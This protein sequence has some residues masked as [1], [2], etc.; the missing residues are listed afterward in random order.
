[1]DELLHS[2]KG[3]LSRVWLASHMEKKLSK[4]QFLT[5]SISDSVQA[6]LS[7]DLLLPAEQQNTA[8]SSGKRRAQDDE[9]LQATP[10][11]LRIQGQLLLGL[12]R[13][14]SRKARYLM[15][16]CSEALVKIKLAFSTVAMQAPV[17]ATE[18]A[19]TT[20]ASQLGGLAGLGTMPAIEMDP[21]KIKAKRSAIT[22]DL[23]PVD[24]LQDWLMTQ[25]RPPS[26]PSTSSQLTQAR[27]LQADRASITLPDTRGSSPLSF[28]SGRDFGRSAPR[29]GS[30]D[31][32]SDASQSGDRADSFAGGD[33]D[34][35][36]LDLGLADHVSEKE[37]VR[38]NR[39]RRADQLR[40]QRLAQRAGGSQAEADQSEDMEV[41]LGRDAA[42]HRSDRSSILSDVAPF[43]G[44][45]DPYAIDDNEYGQGSDGSRS[46]RGGFELE[47]DLYGD[48]EQALRAQTPRSD[49][50]Q[51]SLSAL[52]MTPRTA[53]QLAKVASPTKTTTR[54]RAATRPGKLT[55]D[56]E[57]ELDE[58]SQGV[59]GQTTDEQRRARGIIIQPAYLPHSALEARL[60]EMENN[61]TRFFLPRPI[62]G[63]EGVFMWPPAGLLAPELQRMYTVP[64]KRVGRAS[65]LAP[66]RKRQRSSEDGSDRE[67]EL[68]RNA[69]PTGARMSDTRSQ[70]GFAQLDVY[71]D[72]GDSP[73][74][75][76]FDD[77][78]FE[79]EDNLWN[80]YPDVTL[81]GPEAAA[82]AKEAQLRAA[83]ASTR[84]LTPTAGDTEIKLPKGES[85]LD[86]FDEAD[87]TT[88]S[89][90]HSSPYGSQQT[91][92]TPRRR[93]PQTI[94]GTPASQSQTTSTGSVVSK[95]TIKALLVYRHVLG[96]TADITAPK[97]L[98]VQTVASS[99]TRHAASAFFFET[100]VLSSR[101]AVQPK[102]E[103]AYGDITVKAKPEFYNML[104]S[105]SLESSGSVA[106]SQGKLSTPVV[107]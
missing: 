70:D 57:I 106:A 59:I 107:A 58:T 61:P 99:A 5:L 77:G 23:A 71:D 101:G 86:V 15:E 92:S 14:Y 73:T 54:K 45:V 105:L 1:M 72:F 4:P 53:A 56:D 94:D 33:G 84:L 20:Q 79:N 37:R 36:E 38:R 6:I 12:V 11:G 93:A 52:L 51:A 75:P 30:Q 82:A 90:L 13:V 91:P 76:R 74:R 85:L 63:Q 88:A 46:D 103:S 80:D 8:R 41:E 64:S 60:R 43:K 55:I 83:R 67:V 66:A 102:Q 18:P 19:G 27:D 39:D 47:P 7:S 69:P 87:S 81:E 26:F 100:L 3:A 32:F 97:Q 42:T 31:F 89:Q 50:A 29:W 98:S 9:E 48:F 96:D 28:R 16:D 65:E 104:A 40:A 21:D 44:G 22:L 25:P 10:I 24:P 62:P 2:K 49:P 17:V 68:G 35:E 78:G 95:N 34:E